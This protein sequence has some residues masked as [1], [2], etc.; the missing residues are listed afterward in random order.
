MRSRSLQLRLR[1]CSYSLAA[2]SDPSVRPG[3]AMSEARDA[4]KR[5]LQEIVALSGVSRAALSRILGCLAEDG[6]AAEERRRVGEALADHGRHVTPYGAVVKE[7]DLPG[8]ADGEKT[9]YVCPAA[10]L[11]YLCT[12]CAAFGN[13]L[14]GALDGQPARLVFYV[15][16]VT[17]GNA[18]RPDRGR[19]VT[20]VYWTVL[21][22]PA[23]LRTRSHGWFTL[24]TIR[25]SKLAACAGKVS[26]FLS[27]LLMRIFV[28]G[29]DLR[30]PGIRVPWRGSFLHI[31][32]KLEGFLS[33]E[34]AL[35]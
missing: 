26:G 17:P 14:A 32:A 35:K 6:D 1:G 27:R 2:H 31:C 25:A 12:L 5:R 7:I 23:W 19:T 28:E 20:C 30:D 21:Q 34:K 22:F 24:C 4:R 9:P 18:L 11:Y 29:R 13:L 8:A 33:D 15:D 10:F 16:D 3:A